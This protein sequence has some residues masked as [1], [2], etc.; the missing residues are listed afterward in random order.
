MSE[1]SF[2]SS[3][4][5]ISTHIF[6]DEV[7]SNKNIFFSN[8][9]RISR[10]NRVQ[11]EKQFNNVS[12]T[13]LPQKIIHSQEKVQPL[14]LYLSTSLTVAFRSGMRATSAASGILRPSKTL[15][16][17]SR[18]E[19][20]ISGCRESSYKD[21]DIVLEI[22]KHT[23]HKSI[24]KRRQNLEKRRTEVLF[25]P[26][27]HLQEEAR[28]RCCRRFSG[29]DP[30]GT[31]SMWDNGPPPSLHGPLFLLQPSGACQYGLLLQE[32]IELS[33]YE[34]KITT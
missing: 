15:N 18:S 4:S 21:Q 6:R 29:A 25:L 13:H 9:P 34:S 16:T 12:T 26:C 8:D 11:P 24:K 14:E 2:P 30:S 22:C 17:S 27:Q 20:C 33:N 3:H 28:W 10:N 32:Q 1:L 19:A 7:A 5:Y 31:G 23:G